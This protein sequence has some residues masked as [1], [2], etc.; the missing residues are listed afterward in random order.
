MSQDNVDQLRIYQIRPGMMDEWL[1]LFHGTL[2]NLH[3]EAGIPVINAWRNPSKSQEFVWIRR[4][5]S[6]E[7]VLEQEGVF[8]SLPARVELGD[9]RGKFVETLEVRVLQNCFQG[10]GA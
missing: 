9:V 5:D 3:R 4:F 8:F 1:R 6:V 2:I 10:S 7:S